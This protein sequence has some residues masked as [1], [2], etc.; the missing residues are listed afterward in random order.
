LTEAD[1]ALDENGFTSCGTTM[2]NGAP[3]GTAVCVSPLVCGVE[4]VLDGATTSVSC[5][6]SNMMLYLGATVFSIYMAI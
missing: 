1:C 2:L 5:G 6:A 4:T 3:S